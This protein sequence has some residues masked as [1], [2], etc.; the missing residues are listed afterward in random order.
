MFWAVISRQFSLHTQPN[1]S[2]SRPIQPFKLGLNL[3]AHPYQLGEPV[4]VIF[5]IQ[6]AISSPS[7]Y[8]PCLLTVNCSLI[9][10]FAH[11]FTFFTSNRNRYSTKT[12]TP[13]S[14]KCLKIRQSPD[15]KRKGIYKAP[16]L[17][18]K[19]ALGVPVYIIFRYSN[20]D[21]VPPIAQVPQQNDW[22]SLIL[23][24]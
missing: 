8:T 21:T 7:N 15:R 12:T 2:L 16:V 18:Y 20:Q 1:L 10:I 14:C 23:L 19:E 3:W 24:S 4:L 11:P 5:P 6:V 13:S 17:G 22:L 9:S